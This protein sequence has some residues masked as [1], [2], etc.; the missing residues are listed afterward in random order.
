MEADGLLEYPFCTKENKICIVRC[1]AGTWTELGVA[2][3]ARC[4]VF[5]PPQSDRMECD[6]PMF[7]KDPKDLTEDERVSRYYVAPD[8]DTDA[9]GATTTTASSTTN[10]FRHGSALR[11]SCK[12]EYQPHPWP[13][14]EEI[15]CRDGRWSIPTL[16]CYTPCREELDLGKMRPYEDVQ[17]YQTAEASDNPV[18]EAEQYQ[19]LKTEYKAL[20]SDPHSVRSSTDKDKLPVP[21]KSESKALYMHGFRYV[22]RCNPESDATAIIKQPYDFATCWD[23]EWTD[24]SIMCR[25][26]CGDPYKVFAAIHEVTSN[27]VIETSGTTHN[28]IAHVTCADGFSPAAGREPE[29]IECN[30]GQWWT[31]TLRCNRNCPEYYEYAKDADPD[32]LDDTRYVKQGYSGNTNAGSSFNLT[33]GPFHTAGQLDNLPGGHR[34]PKVRQEITCLDGKWTARLLHCFHNCPE[35]APENPLDTDT[36]FG[37]G[38]IVEGV[39]V[40]DVRD[41]Q[42]FSAEGELHIQHGATRKIKCCVAGQKL[43]QGPDPALESGKCVWDWATED[44]MEPREASVQCSDGLWTRP[45]I[46]CR[47]MCEALGPEHELLWQGSAKYMTSKNKPGKLEGRK[48]ES[49]A[50]MIYPGYW[51]NIR[52]APGYLPEPFQGTDFRRDWNNRP[53]A[54]AVCHNGYFTHVPFECIKQCPTPVDHWEP[55]ARVRAVAVRQPTSNPPKISGLVKSSPWVVRHGQSFYTYCWSGSKAAPGRKQRLEGDVSYYQRWRG[56]CYF[57]C[58]TTF[59]RRKYKWTWNLKHNLMD[60]NA[61]GDAP[62][63]MKKYQCFYGKWVGKD[64]PMVCIQLVRLHEMCIDGGT[65]VHV[66]GRSS[67]VALRHVRVGD[68]VLSW[69]PAARGGKGQLTYAE[70]YFRQSYGKKW[71]FTTTITFARRDGKAPL[72]LSPTHRLPICRMLTRRKAR[73]RPT[74]D[75][76]SWMMGGGWRHRQC[77]EMLAGMG[78]DVSSSGSSTVSWSV[79]W[80]VVA[81]KDVRRGDWLMVYDKGGNATHMQL[82][83]VLEAHT[84]IEHRAMELVYT[85]TGYLVGGGALV[86]DADEPLDEYLPW[87]QLTNLDTRLVYA[88]FGPDAVQSDLFQTFWRSTGHLLTGFQRYAERWFAAAR[89]L[90]WSFL[91]LPLS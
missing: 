62:D 35:F 61:A 17:L 80:L 90:A 84:S 9:A 19:S 68:R 82:S 89:S 14:E 23:G 26:S 49:G 72:R 74:Y 60:Y 75:L 81:A 65:S 25:K 73:N 3:F 85:T 30:D 58:K 42:R 76:L 37:S 69:R 13:Q 44:N 11:L 48:G 43:R 33:C 83:Q 77:A 71:T 91:L 18:T 16:E 38:Y 78:V 32:V 22:V 79:E 5:V 1:T 86:T 59:Y 21:D 52:C 87:T 88:L 15:K 24:T 27:Y 8:N 41:D 31:P 45:D 36:L 67:P 12:K 46:M 70:V 2:C 53:Q 66:A 4:P 28:S 29:R 20:P 64:P 7:C 55:D 51:A 47:P 54:R 34:G 50:Q 56:Q 40:R 6:P 57:G 39:E 10:V 63:D